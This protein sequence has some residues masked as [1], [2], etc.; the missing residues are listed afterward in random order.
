SP[1]PS[2]LVLFSG[3]RVPRFTG[4]QV[5][6]VRPASRS[7]IRF[8]VRLRDPGQELARD[9]GDVAVLDIGGIVHGPH[10]ARGN[11][12]GQ[13]IERDPGGGIAQQCFRASDGRGI[14][15]RKIVAVVLELY[16]V[17]RLDQTGRGIAGNQVDLT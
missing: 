6:R 9:C 17:E 15:R 3:S 14:I 5:L 11:A 7:W 12:A 4:S 16:E 8:T 1:V 13:P 10:F 2:S